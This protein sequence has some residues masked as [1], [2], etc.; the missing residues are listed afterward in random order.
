MPRYRLTIMSK[1]TE[2]AYV[3][4]DSESAARQCYIDGAFDVRYTT[5]LDEL[6]Q[7]VEEDEPSIP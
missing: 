6:L 3:D 2:I 5:Y 1:L 4:A 7:S